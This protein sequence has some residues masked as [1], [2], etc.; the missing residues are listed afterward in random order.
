MPGSVTNAAPATVLPY[1][2][3]R[4]FARSQEH[5][6][7]ENEYRNG[8]SQRRAITATSRKRWRQA[9]RLT[10][11]ALQVLREFYNAR[12]GLQ[13]TFWFYDP[14]ETN[15]K[16]SHDPMGVAVVGRYAVRFASEWSQEVTLGCADVQIEIVEVS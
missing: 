13:E 6:V 12:N 5:V 9:K 11:A 7:D 1:S 3:S 14:W 10:P 15:P 4:A 8:E 2:L 16:F